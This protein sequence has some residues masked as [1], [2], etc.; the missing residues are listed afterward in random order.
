MVSCG[1]IF[2]SFAP[3]GGNDS[4]YCFSTELNHRSFCPGA[5]HHV[6]FVPVPETSLAAK[7][8]YVPWHGAWSFGCLTFCQ[9]FLTEAGFRFKVKYKD[10]M[11]V[12]RWFNMFRIKLTSVFLPG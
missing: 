9:N 10:V 7:R 12:K 8:H 1:F 2:F 4:I 5:L 11:A 6:K 3:T